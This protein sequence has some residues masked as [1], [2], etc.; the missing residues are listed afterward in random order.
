MTILARRIRGGLMLAG[1][2]AA[3]W[4][5]LGATFRIVWPTETGLGLPTLAM[6]LST[7][8]HWIFP[9]AI[10]GSLFAFSLAFGRRSRLEE[11]SS[12]RL[13]LSG[14][15]AATVIPTAMLI[16]SSLM[17]GRSYLGVLPLVLQYGVAGGVCA[18][19]SFLLARRAHEPA[20]HATRISGAA[21]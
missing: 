10:T 8:S 18:T 5:C 13:G 17:T 16:A 15:A 4:A 6:V 2:W 19:G 7:G 20:Q 3:A 9:G 11:Y 14:A 1:T 12:L 21:T